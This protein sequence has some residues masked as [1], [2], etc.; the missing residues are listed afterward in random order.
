MVRIFFHFPVEMVTV[1]SAVGGTTRKKITNYEFFIFLILNENQNDLF[2][3][4][5][6]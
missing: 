2:F 3:F 5:V 1:T 4:F 6:K